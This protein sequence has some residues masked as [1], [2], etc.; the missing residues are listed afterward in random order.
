M[1]E[2]RERTTGKVIPEQQFRS[3]YSNVSFPDPMQD[4]IL[5]EMG[6][7]RIRPGVQPS[8]SV[9]YQYVYRNGEE[10]ISGIWTEKWSVGT[11]VTATIDASAAYAVRV[12]RDS[13]LA[14]TDWLVTKSVDT[15]VSMGSSWTTYRQELRDLP[16]S[17]GFPHS[18]TWPTEPSS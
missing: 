16:N 11:G 9:P 7:D 14:K 15:G 1:A 18:V 13:K 8:F 4:A 3:Q 6:Y 10:Q 12:E 17:S 5:D 2:Y